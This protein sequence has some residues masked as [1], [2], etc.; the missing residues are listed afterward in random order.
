M[1][2]TTPKTEQ[3]HTV[4]IMGGSFFARLGIHRALQEM[5]HIQPHTPATD[6]D[7]VE[8]SDNDIILYIISK[9]NKTELTADNL[10][11]SNYLLL[12]TNGSNQSA[13]HYMQIGAKAIIDENTLEQDILTAIQHI[14]QEKLFI[15]PTLQLNLLEQL[16]MRSR[17]KFQNVESFPT[18]F[19]PILRKLARNMPLERIAEEEDITLNTLMVYRS[20]L[21][22]ELDIPKKMSFSEYAR[23]HPNVVAE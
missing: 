4:H 7:I 1:T 14:R 9:D 16:I 5:A 3:T 18:R 20:R 17:T 12:C 21:R 23:L 11:K 15:S 2:Q 19:I 6:T 8:N 10:S 22:K 13:I